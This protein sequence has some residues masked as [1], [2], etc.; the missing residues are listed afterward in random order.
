[1]IRHVVLF[2]WTAE[3]TAEQRAAVRDG[4]AALPREIPAIAAYSVG[5]DLNLSDASWDL[6]V[7]A[8]FADEAAWLAYRDHPAHQAVIRERIAPIRAD[9]ARVQFRVAP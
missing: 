6:A 2:R 4:L 7:V 3:A 9:I 1:M 8:D 5:H